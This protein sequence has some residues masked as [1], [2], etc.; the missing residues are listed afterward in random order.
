MMMRIFWVM[1]ASAQATWLP[2]K[3]SG[4][5]SRTWLG[6]G[7]VCSRESGPKHLDQQR[8]CFSEQGISYPPRGTPSHTTTTCYICYHDLIPVKCIYIYIHFK[9]AI[10]K[11]CKTT[12]ILPR[13]ICFLHQ[14]FQPVPKTMSSP[15]TSPWF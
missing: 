15:W 4:N 13:M 10:V 9:S 11:P 14:P 7:Q 6:R 8:S 5:C 1:M 2:P 3:A 12:R